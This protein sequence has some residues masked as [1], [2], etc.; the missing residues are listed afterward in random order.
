MGTTLVRDVLDT[1]T[2][3][4]PANAWISYDCTTCDTTNHIAVANELIRQGYLDNA[5]AP[6]FVDTRQIAIPSLRVAVGA[7]GIRISNLN[8][9][10]YIAP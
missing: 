3:S 4:F 10:W 6:R 7:G 2:R 5:P 8:L 9:S 1:A